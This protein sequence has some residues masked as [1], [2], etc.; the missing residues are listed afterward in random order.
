MRGVGILG[1]GPGVSALHVPTIARADCDLRI[2][3]IA[4]GGSGRAAAIA[5]RV[6]ARASAGVAD[7]LADDRV[8]VVAICTPPGEHADQVRAAVASGARAVL[9]EKPL[10]TTA[11]DARA[12]VDTCREAG[13]ALLVGTNHLFDPAWTRAK[14]HLLASGGRVQTVS[15]T[16]SLPPNSRY[17]DLVSEGTAPSA[18]GGARPPLDEPD[19]AAAVVRQLVIGLA[20][21]DLPL[22]R[23]LVPRFDRVVFAR[24][25]P[26]IGYAIGLDCGGVLVTLTAT[27]QN[28]GAD[29]L[30]RMVIGTSTSRVEV[31]FPPAFVHRGSAAVQVDDA[32]GRTTR[33]PPVDEDGYVAEWRALTAMLD[34]DAPRE[35]DELLDDALFAI[36]VADAAAEAVR[37]GMR[38]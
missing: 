15:V 38:A 24:L 34:G 11:E 21:H 28:G 19:V 25:L 7:L 35:Y 29:A 33:Y 6:G 31:D 8:E 20:V 26:P 36:E 13:V 22:V 14:H 30:W 27:M 16:L 18:A 12:V 3:H 17:H 2:V 32:H 10:A 4:D 23:D 37:D 5:E 1:A 9:C